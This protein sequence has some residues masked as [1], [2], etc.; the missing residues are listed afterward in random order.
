MDTVRPGAKDLAIEFHS[1]S[2]SFSMAGWRVGFAV[3]N[4]NL[5]NGL[6]SLKTNC[7]YGLASAMQDAAI[8]ALQMDKQFLLD[9]NRTYQ[10]RRNLVVDG[11]REMGWDLEYPK[12]TMYVWFRVPEGYDS[13]SWIKSVLDKTGVCMTPGIAFGQHSDGYFR[14]SLVQ[15][16]TK[17][18]EA[19]QRLK[20]NNISFK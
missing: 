19:I 5:I 15:N 11:F 4:K 3:G 14:I 6:F 2:K 20:D 10:R 13:K 18:Q 9:I 1:C 8:A 12:A 17:L 7:D 16:D